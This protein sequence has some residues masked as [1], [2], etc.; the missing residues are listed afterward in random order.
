MYNCLKHRA[1]ASDI[2]IP[3][4][5]YQASLAMGARLVLLAGFRGVTLLQ[6]NQYWA[7]S[8]LK[9]VVAELAEW[10]RLKYLPAA[11][12]CDTTFR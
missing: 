1:S 7:S 2:I 11:E 6:R 8:A 12:K 10:R 5:G 4:P 9:I 3:W